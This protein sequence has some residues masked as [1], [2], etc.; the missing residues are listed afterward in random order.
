MLHLTLTFW[1]Y[2][3][4][5]YKIWIKIFWRFCITKLSMDKHTEWHCNY[6]FSSAVPPLLSW[7]LSSNKLWLQSKISSVILYI[8]LSA[9]LSWGSLFQQNWFILRYPIMLAYH[10]MTCNVP[11][12]LGHFKLKLHTKQRK[13]SVLVAGSVVLLY[14]FSYPISLPLLIVGVVIFFY[15]SMHNLHLFSFHSNVIMEP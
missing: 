3:Y 11:I 2:Y 15:S 6:Y 10:L 14:F 7:G 4:S 12:S 13:W 5:E 8:F 9:S 1:P